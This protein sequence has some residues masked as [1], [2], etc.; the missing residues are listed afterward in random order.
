MSVEAEDFL[1]FETYRDAKDHAFSNHMVSEE[2]KDSYNAIFEHLR[3][4][5]EE[6][7]SASGT[8]DEFDRWVCSFGRDGG[9]Q[10][11]RP[12]SLWASVINRN[13]EDFS[14]FPQVYII[15]AETGLEIGFSVTIHED[16]YHDIAVKQK[17]RAIV[18]I[19][20]AKLPDPQSAMI[21]SIQDVLESEP[22]WIFAEKSRGGFQSSYAGLPHLVA[23]LK[24]GN[25]SDKGGGAV[26]RMLSS[27]EATTSADR[28]SKELLHVLELFR[29]VMQILQST[30]DERQLARNML[31]I[32]RAGEQIPGFDP[33]DD[34]D[35]RTRMLREVAVRQGAA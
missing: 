18:P 13:S 17:N 22:G 24:S 6:V 34:E 8:P 12:K 28:L 32:A 7:I 23:H 3:D 5:V 20:N 21:T 26:Y 29:P 10:G 11:H 35:G 16:G 25:S 4:A 19:I 15:A 31:E 1:V 30:S 2:D 14:R 33:H 27:E 9:A